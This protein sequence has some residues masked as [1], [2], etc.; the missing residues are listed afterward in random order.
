MRSSQT[1]G[2]PK[3]SGRDEG[4]VSGEDPPTQLETAESLF[5][6]GKRQLKADTCSALG[7][8]SMA[9][10]R[11]GDLLP[12]RIALADIRFPATPGE[13]VTLAEQAIAQASI[14]DAGIICFPEFF[15]PGYRTVGTAAPPP[16]L[17]HEKPLALGTV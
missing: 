15:V 10:M 1:A 5:G 14:E 3:R 12:L 9:V 16:D 7:F 8:A 4:R 2:Y 17:H 13:S 6:S 11:S